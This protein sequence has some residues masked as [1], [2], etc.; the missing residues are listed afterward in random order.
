MLESN[1]RPLLD[2]SLFVSSD[3]YNERT[4]PALSGCYPWPLNLSISHQLRSCAEQRTE[5][6]GITDLSLN[7]GGDGTS[8]ALI[9]ASTA[10]IPSSF[11]K[12]PKSDVL[13]Q[14]KKTQQ[15]RLRRL[16]GEFAAPL[17]ALLASKRFLI[18]EDQPTSLDCLAVGYLQ[19]ACIRELPLSWLADALRTEFETLCTYMDDYLCQYSASLNWKSSSHR[20]TESQTP[21][22]LSSRAAGGRYP[23]FQLHPQNNSL[24]RRT[25]MPVLLFNRTMVALP[26]AKH[27]RAAVRLSGTLLEDEDD[28]Y[29]QA[30]RQYRVAWGVLFAAAAAGLCFGSYLFNVMFS[31]PQQGSS[32][33]RRSDFGSLGEAGAAHAVFSSETAQR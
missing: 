23:S 11:L 27:H 15:F 14:I 21:E 22:R 24:L 33:T 9:A 3:N 6:L 4:K 13:G 17:Q 10:G 28:Y 8:S 29:S 26:L 30:S 7:P 19:V 16:V 31:T 2:L 1:G 5:H 12:I 18:S 25:S 20:H 32:I